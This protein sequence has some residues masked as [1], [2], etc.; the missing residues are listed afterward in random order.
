M[1]TELSAMNAIVYGIWLVV[2]RS[3]AANVPTER[4]EPLSAIK[5]TY[6]N[7]ESAVNPEYYRTKM[8]NA[9][10][11]NAGAPVVHRKLGLSSPNEV[12]VYQTWLRREFQAFGEFLADYVCLR[13]KKCWAN[14]GPREYLRKLEGENELEQE[15]LL[16]A[17]SEAEFLRTSENIMDIF[18]KFFDIGYCGFENIK[19]IRPLITDLHEMIAFNNKSK[20]TKIIDLIISIDEV[21]EEYLR[22]CV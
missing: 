19:A 2:L 16:K 21:V 3:G 6:V 15:Q 7:Y 18:D 5:G 22:L 17:L 13:R 8:G 10:T 11:E 1:Q 14:S 20:L 12:L 4:H 9:D